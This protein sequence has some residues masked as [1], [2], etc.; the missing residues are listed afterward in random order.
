MWLLLFLCLWLFP[1]FSM[2]QQQA[3]E[4]RYFV[5][6]QVGAVPFAEA[7]VRI[8]NEPY[9]FREVLGVYQPAVGV[10][11]GKKYKRFAL[12]GGLEYYRFESGN[13]RHTRQE[14]DVFYLYQ[15]DVTGFLLSAPV[16][17][18]WQ[19]GQKKLR[20]ELESGV[21]FVFLQHRI[22][23]GHFASVNP[24]NPFV[25]SAPHKAS[26]TRFVALPF[27][28][29]GTGFSFVPNKNWEYGMRFGIVGIP[30]VDRWEYVNLTVLR[31][32]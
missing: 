12:E 28:R 22:E 30:G 20:F 29:I 7:P 4:K 19:F 16:I 23:E 13:Q 11:V 5:S 26:E 14:A 2:A 9:S 6:L 27:P 24:I 31:P 17:G 18:R 32:F 25:A 8:Y 21:Q 10:R 1:A 15:Y 3:V